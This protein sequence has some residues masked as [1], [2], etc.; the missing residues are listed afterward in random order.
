MQIDAPIPVEIRI[1]N[2]VLC[3][4]KIPLLRQ[5]PEISQIDL[6]VHPL[7]PRN[8]RQRLLA[9]LHQPGLRIPHQI[10]HPNPAIQIQITRQT[11]YDLIFAQIRTPCP[12]PNQ[13][14]PVPHQLNH[15]PGS[16]AAIIIIARQFIR[17]RT[18]V[19]NRHGRIDSTA[20]RINHIRPPHARPKPMPHVTTIVPPTATA[21]TAPRR[22]QRRPA[23]DLTIQQLNRIITVIIHR[24]RI[25]FL[26]RRCH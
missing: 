17:I 21:V 22:P 9:P 7:Q 6:P 10:H 13:I 8:I 19:E 3:P 4:S 24:R 12:H 15:Y 18:P 11:H 1:F 16:R 20:P 14:H 5:Q 25:R 26:K 23:V 2:P